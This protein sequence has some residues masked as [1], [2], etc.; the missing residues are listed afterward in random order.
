M[1]TGIRIVPLTFILCTHTGVF[2][3]IRVVRILQGGLS[4]TKS[5]TVTGPVH[6]V[7]FKAGS[8]VHN[9]PRQSVG[10]KRIQQSI[11]SPNSFIFH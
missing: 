8:Q 11:N 1:C 6:R 9:F 3:K 5:V 7:V 10:E 2:H 4:L